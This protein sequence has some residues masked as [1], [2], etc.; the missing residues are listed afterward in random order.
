ML[1]ID[2]SNNPKDVEQSQTLPSLS[3]NQ[4][5]CNQ[6]KEQERL[7]QSGYLVFSMLLMLV[8]YTFLGSDKEKNF[9]QTIALIIKV[10]LAGLFYILHHEGVNYFILSGV[11]VLQIVSI[12][13]GD[14]PFVFY[15]F[16][17]NFEIRFPASFIVSFELFC[18]VVNA[19]F[20]SKKRESN[21][22]EVN[23]DNSNTI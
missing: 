9:I 12:L 23:Q 6:I 20:I 13:V 1:S 21:Q 10:L 3:N 14:F 5:E 4:Q 8:C 22:L 16:G 18:L 19:L 15:G 11:S 7:P 17:N 2:E